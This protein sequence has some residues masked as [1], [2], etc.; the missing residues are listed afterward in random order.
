ML[1]DI[2]IP[3]FDHLHQRHQIAAVKRVMRSHE[4]HMRLGVSGKPTARCRIWNQ[5]AA[6][7][8]IE[9]GNNVNHEVVKANRDRVA[10]PAD[11]GRS[12]IGSLEGA[13]Y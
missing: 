8:P 5:V 10:T 13:L 6:A 3:S 12:G 1:V 11:V 7:A 9:A 4:L 2:S